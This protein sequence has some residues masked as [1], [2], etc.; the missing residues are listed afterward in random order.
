[1]ATR[2]I[3]CPYCNAEMMIDDDWASAFCMYCGKEIDISQFSSD[4]MTSEISYPN[5][6]DHL[7]QKTVSAKSVV[8][9]R[10]N[11]APLVIGIILAVVN[12]LWSLMSGFRSTFAII[13]LLLGV[14]LICLYGFL[15]SKYDKDVKEAMMKGYTIKNK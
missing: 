3:K 10:P 1:M 14:F 4:P 6:N 15:S 11:A 13:M 8:I 2:T 5:S 9:K 12:T 7:K